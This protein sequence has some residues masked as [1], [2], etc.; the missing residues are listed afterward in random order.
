MHLPTITST[1]GLGGTNMWHIQHH[2]GATRESYWF[3][4]K[5]MFQKL[6]SELCTLLVFSPVQSNLK[7]QQ[8]TNLGR[9]ISL[10][11]DLKFF[12]HP[13]IPSG[14]T[15]RDIWHSWELTPSHHLCVLHLAVICPSIYATVSLHKSVATVDWQ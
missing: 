5:I 12:L 4:G 10:L 15:W 7:S 3:P 13:P 6:I 9:A 2:M 1:S 14:D 11:A 8:S